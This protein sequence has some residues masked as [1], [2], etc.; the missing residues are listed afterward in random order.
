MADEGDPQFLEVVGGQARQNRGVDAM[1]A[2]RRFVLLESETVQ[3]S[4][5]IHGD[6]LA[7]PITTSALP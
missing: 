7:R 4:R 1:L 3:P 2:E 6:L 5:D